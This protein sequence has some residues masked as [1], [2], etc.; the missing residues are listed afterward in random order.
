M[1]YCLF[2]VYCLIATHLFKIWLDLFNQDSDLSSDEKVLSLI[3]LICATVFWPIVLP[4]AYSKLL[5]AKRLY[6]LSRGHE[7]QL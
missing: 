3:T 4:I 7:V 1:N 5:S 2:C 6:S